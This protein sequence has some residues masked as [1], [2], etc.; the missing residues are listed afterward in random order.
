MLKIEPKKIP[1]NNVE[2][3][4][5]AIDVT[6]IDIAEIVTNLGVEDDDSLA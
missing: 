1:D 3:P 5:L 2:T 6:E 4:S